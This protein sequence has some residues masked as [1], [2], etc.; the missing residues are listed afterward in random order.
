MK[1]TITLDDGRRVV[2]RIFDAGPEVTDR[3]TVAF[4]GRRVTGYGMTYPYLASGSTPFHPQ[5]YGQ[6]GESSV[7][8]KG[9]HLG[10]RVA[11]ESVPADVQK[12]ILQQFN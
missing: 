5:G 10:K 8:L 12:F 9:A 4:K 7:F 3:Y 2:C 1:N 6:H 11:F